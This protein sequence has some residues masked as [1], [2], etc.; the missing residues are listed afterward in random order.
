MTLMWKTQS[1]LISKLIKAPHCLIKFYCMLKVDN[2]VN[3]KE[4]L[5]VYELAVAVTTFGYIYIFLRFSSLF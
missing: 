1:A 2:W 5:D 4:N 3:N